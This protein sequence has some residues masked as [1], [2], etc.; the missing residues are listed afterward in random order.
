M[1]KRN[2][3]VT[4]VR[5]TNAN[6]IS[7]GM[8]GF[9]FFVG[10]LCN[11]PELPFNQST[12]EV[13]PAY[14]LFCAL[15][16]LLLINL[17]L[18]NL[19]IEPGRKKRMIADLM[20]MNN[21]VEATVVAFPRNHG[22]RINKAAPYLLEC[23]YEDEVTGITHV[24]YGN[25]FRMPDYRMIGCRVKVYLDRLDPSRYYVDLT[26]IKMPAMPQGSFG[27]GVVR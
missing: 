8:G 15:M 17:S 19:V 1:A 26:Q 7:I 22:N 3:S 2:G 10:V 11:H 23:R 14:G 25:E 21:T 20:R 27:G 13:S 5:S 9:L 24:Y 12:K 16:G 6:L 4:Y 18:T